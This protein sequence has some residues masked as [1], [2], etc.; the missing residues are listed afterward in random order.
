M[1]RPPSS[2]ALRARRRGRW[3]AW[4]APVLAV[5]LVAALLC[6]AAANVVVRAGWRELVDGVLWVDRPGGV[7]AAEVA[8]DEAGNRAGIEAGGAGG[9][10][11]DLAPR[12]APAQL[13]G[14]A[15]SGHLPPEAT[16]PA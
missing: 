11:P 4:V 14:P 1:S 10:P 3:R 15:E 8:P 12:S 6:L 9:Y 13:A 2:H 7:T 16:R 5:A